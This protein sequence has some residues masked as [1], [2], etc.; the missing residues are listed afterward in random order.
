M[1][2]LKTFAISQLIFSS[3]FQVISP[4]DVRKIEHLCYSFLWNGPDQIKRVFLKSGWDEGG[5]NRID[6]EL[7]FNSIAVRQFFKSYTNKILAFVNDS[8]NFKEDIKTHARSI[9]RKLLLHQINSLEASDTL[10]NQW[11]SQTRA[12]FLVQPYSKSH[13]LMGKLGIGN[14]SSISSIPLR[15]GKLSQIR[16]ALP[17]RA[18]LVVDNPNSNIVT[19]SISPKALV[20]KLMTVLKWFYV[21]RLSIILLTNIQ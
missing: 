5:I 18:L 4:K 17:S 21:K 12:D 16:R 7:F 11:I 19:N 6:I 15:R 10:N 9:I 20:R 2:I 1:I 3:Q 13:Q 14:I 8:P